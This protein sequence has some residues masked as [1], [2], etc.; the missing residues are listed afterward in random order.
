[1]WLF[2]GWFWIEHLHIQNKNAHDNCST[3]DQHLQNTNSPSPIGVAG[4]SCS[5]LANLPRPTEH[6]NTSETPSKEEQR[7]PSNSAPGLSRVQR[8][9]DK[10]LRLKRLWKIPKVIWK[11]GKVEMC[12]E[13]LDP[14]EELQDQFRII[15]LL[16]WGGKTLQ[17]IVV[18]RRLT[19]FFPSN[20]YINT[21]VQKGG[22]GAVPRRLKHPSVVTQLIRE[23]CEHKG[24]LTVLWLDLAN[25]YGS[26]PHKRVQT[27][28]TKHRMQHPV[29]DLKEDYYNFRMRRLSVWG[30]GPE[31]AS[32]SCPS[33]PLWMIWQSPRYGWIL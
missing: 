19:T 28:I 3:S 29:A 30:A 31:K 14:Q 15:W 20:N 21:S 27:V 25:A 11:R 7:P 17:Y 13:P 26:I 4:G 18:G 10:N 6:F 5:I 22:I 2:L 1:M 23:A 9:V 32:V 16:I 33:G 24:D 12:R 8:K